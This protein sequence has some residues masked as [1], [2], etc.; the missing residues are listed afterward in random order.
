MPQLVVEAIPHPGRIFI[1]RRTNTPVF[2]APGTI[3]TDLPCARA[4]GYYN[5]LSYISHASLANA[6]VFVRIDLFLKTVT[7]KLKYTYNMKSADDT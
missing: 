1:L 4:L 7:L 2:V 5:I 6:V 3:P